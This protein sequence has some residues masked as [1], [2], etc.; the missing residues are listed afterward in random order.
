MCARGRE[1]RLWPLSGRLK[2]EPPET[3]STAWFVTP[4]GGPL[5]AA[6]PRTSRR[7]P[8]PPAAMLDRVRVRD[9]AALGA[10]Y[11]HYF[12]FVYGLAFRLVGERASA[13]DVT[14]DVFMKVHR[15]AESID[16]GRDPAPW[17]ATITANACRDLWR[18]GAYRMSRAGRPTE[19]DPETGFA[20][21]PGRNDP[22]ADALA[23][24]RERLVQAAIGRLPEVLRVPVVLHDYQGLDHS[25]IAG[26][27][28]IAHSAARKRYSRALVAL[29]SMLRETLG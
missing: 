26:M 21:T 11:D 13:E 8:P 25:E 27:L 5:P 17:L 18:S 12:D 7:I 14:Q 22:Q 24:E 16:S 9:G 1:I 20:L 29:G 4:V 23:A 6:I 28:G 19:D 15:A 2:S 3:H 10:F